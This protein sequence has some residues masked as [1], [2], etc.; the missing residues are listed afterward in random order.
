MAR[1]STHFMSIRR[2]RAQWKSNGLLLLFCTM[3][4]IRSFQHLTIY[5]CWKVHFFPKVRYVWRALCKVVYDAHDVVW[6]MYSA[7]VCNMTGT[8]R[9]AVLLA[10][11]IPTIRS[12]ALFLASLVF[13]TLM[14]TQRWSTK[15]LH[16]V[17]FGKDFIKARFQGA[18]RS[19]RTGS[20]ST[21]FM[22]CSPL[23]RISSRVCPAW[24]PFESVKKFWRICV[25]LMPMGV[26]LSCGISCLH[27]KCQ[28]I[29]GCGILASRSDPSQGEFWCCAT[30]V[31]QGS[32][33]GFHIAAKRLY[34]RLMNDTKVQ[35]QKEL[36]T[37]VGEI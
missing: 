20:T 5:I 32:V 17:Q 25:G 29:R 35:K 14:F 21:A 10:Q 30:L 12:P 22:P 8:V 1:L 2:L 26:H 7:D 9:H 31:V 27:V 11:H 34:H 36:K 23:Q 24:T 28:G 15:V 16:I 18:L 6:M 19:F 33:S 3:I 13:T 37:M 4:V